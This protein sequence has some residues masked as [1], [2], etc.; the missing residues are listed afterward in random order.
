MIPY[1]FL[2]VSAL[3]FKFRSI[4]FLHFIHGVIKSGKFLKNCSWTFSKKT[5]P[6][7]PDCFVFQ[8]LFLLCLFSFFVSFLS[9]TNFDHQKLTNFIYDCF[10]FSF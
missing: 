9:I 1:T 4:F 10:G 3:D 8:L 7:F 6:P 2:F 5:I